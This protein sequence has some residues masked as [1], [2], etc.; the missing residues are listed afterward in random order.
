MD[1]TETGRQM[2]EIEKALGGPILAAREAGVTHV[3]WWRWRSGRV[4]PNKTL[5]ALLHEKHGVGAAC[6]KKE[7]T[8]K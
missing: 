3:T 8:R 2:R 4:P 7:S 1:T 6:K 5:I